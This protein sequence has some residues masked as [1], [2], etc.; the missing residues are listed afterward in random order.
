MNR[1]TARLL[2]IVLLAG[3]FVPLALA[4]SAPAPH[5]CCVRKPLHDSSTD[6]T[7]HA[8]ACGNHSC[9]T[10]LTS[11]CWVVSGSRPRTKIDPVRASLLAELPQIFRN[12]EVA[13]SQSVRAP[14]MFSLT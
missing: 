13:N 1:L 14:P 5:A 4:I 6:A 2:L 12:N 9:C 8:F 11:A 3:T 7:L 10:P